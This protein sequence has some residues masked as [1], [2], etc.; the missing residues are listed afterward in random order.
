MKYTGH[1]LS[2]EG[3]SLVKSKLDEIWLAPWPKVSIS[4]NNDFANFLA[5]KPSGF[6]AK[7]VKLL[8]YGP[9]K[10]SWVSKFWLWAKEVLLS[11]QILIK[12]ASGHGIG[13][14]LS[15]VM[16]DESERPV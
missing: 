16:E 2:K 3:I 4:R 12:D 1:I 10:F 13:A 5:I 15:Q 14:E 11:K 6:G 8:F 9:K 7:C